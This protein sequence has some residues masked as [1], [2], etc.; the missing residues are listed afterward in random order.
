[1]NLII[2]LTFHFKITSCFLKFNL[3]KYEFD[4]NLKFLKKTELTTLLIKIKEIKRK[5]HGLG[6]AAK[7]AHLAYGPI[8]ARVWV[9]QT[10]LAHTA[11][12][13]SLLLSCSR[14]PLWRTLVAPPSPGD[15]S[16]LRRV[17]PPPPWAVQ[18]DSLAASSPRTS[19]AGSHSG[20]QLS[21]ATEPAT[22]PA[23]PWCLRCFSEE[24]M[25]CVHAGG[26]W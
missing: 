5:G 2:K 10:D 16:R 21:V 8:K 13:H 24:I 3:I 18:V 26:R 17:P 25:V 1:L 7:P 12:S 22:S 6:P 23:A 14:A 15:P 9:G 4:L 20:I 19:R 11:P